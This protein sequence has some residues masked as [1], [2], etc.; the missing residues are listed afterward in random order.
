MSTFDDPLPAVPRENHK[1]TRLRREDPVSTL[2][3]NMDIIGGKVRSALA[4][5]QGTRVERDR[6]L[7]GLNEIA[8][9]IQMARE[10][11]VPPNVE[12]Y[13][14]SIAA[15]ISWSDEVLAKLRERERRAGGAEELRRFVDWGEPI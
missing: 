3:R 13:L 10:S 8:R 4:E 1:F 9:Y 5:L 15:L 6:A 12:T 2:S 11:G 7:A 14:G